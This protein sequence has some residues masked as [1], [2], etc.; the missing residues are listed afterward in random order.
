MKDENFHRD[1]VRKNLELLTSEEFDREA[2]KRAYRKFYVEQ[3][4]RIDR[5]SGVE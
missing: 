4:K 1:F 3:H 2:Y 5:P